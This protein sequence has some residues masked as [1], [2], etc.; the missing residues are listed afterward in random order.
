MVPGGFQVR[1]G[2]CLNAAEAKGSHKKCVHSGGEACAVGSHLTGASLIL[3][4]LRSIHEAV[5]EVRFMK[6]LSS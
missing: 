1:G 6:L 5:H 2:R 4:E 3:V